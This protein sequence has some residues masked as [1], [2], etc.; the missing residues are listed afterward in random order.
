MSTLPCCIIASEWGA[1]NFSESETGRIRTN[2][3]RHGPS[4]VYSVVP[5]FV[6]PIAAGVGVTLAQVGFILL[7]GRDSQ[8]WVSSKYVLLPICLNP[9]PM[10]DLCL[11]ARVS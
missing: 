11:S 9:D 2:F 7:F 6:C 10:L 1:L 8:T 5:A 3:G 4:F